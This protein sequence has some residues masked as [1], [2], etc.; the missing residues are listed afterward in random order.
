MATHFSTTQISADDRFDYWRDVICRTYVAVTCLPIE[1]E[2]DARVSVN[3]WGQARLT[4]ISSSPMAYSRTTDDIRQLPSDD[5]Q[6]CLIQEGSVAI[7]QD[8]RETTLGPGDIG[9]YDSARPFGMHF[10]EQYRAF[11]LKFPRLSLATRVPSIEKAMALKFAGDS[12]LGALVNSV[13]RESVRVCDFADEQLAA[14]LSGPVLDIVS[15]AIENELL[16]ARGAESRQAIQVEKIKRYMLECLGDED[17]DIATI[18]SE[19]HIAPRTIHRLFAAEGTTAMRWLWQKRLSAS[20]QALAE[21]RVKQVSEA[22]IDCG[23]RDFSHFTRA[24]KKAFGVMPNSLLRK[25][26]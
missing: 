5:I 19:C 7:A 13:L 22:A 15:V 2:L 20:Y 21:G 9:L 6:L 11:V 1:R 17:L 25:S 23:F 3:E 18:A 4:D 14:R 10:G 26:H 24:F 8:G 16:G 12:R